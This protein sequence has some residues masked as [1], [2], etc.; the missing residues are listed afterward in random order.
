MSDGKISKEYE[1]GY[2]KPPKKS[3]FRKGVSGNPRG[4]PR[5]APNFDAQLIQEA[6]SLITV[7]DN[8][9]QKRITKSKGI[10]KQLTN[11][12]LTGNTSAMQNFL[13]VYL[14]ALERVALTAKAEAAESDAKLEQIWEGATE[15]QEDEI[16]LEYAERIKEKRR[17][18]EASETEG[19]EVFETG[20]SE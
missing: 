6:M 12:A 1:V 4:R 3:Q 13:K 17:K 15:E 11:K 8:G 18:R 14:P 20:T 2:A 10:A 16:I 7:N 5:K 19:G 9:H